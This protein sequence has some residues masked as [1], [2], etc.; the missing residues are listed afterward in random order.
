MTYG[1]MHLVAAAAGL[2]V[3]GRDWLP[4]TRVAQAIDEV[5]GKGKRKLGNRYQFQCDFPTDQPQDTPQQG[6]KPMLGGLNSADG[7]GGER[8]DPVYPPRLIAVFETTHP[9]LR[10]ERQPKPVCVVSRLITLRYDCA[11]CDVRGVVC[12]NRMRHSHCAGGARS[13]KLT[14]AQSVSL[15]PPCN[16]RY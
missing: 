14:P 13:E 2:V 4:G 11:I 10:Q 1:D 3:C 16:P 12:P 6:D 5:L 15:Q 8:C 9:S 7:R